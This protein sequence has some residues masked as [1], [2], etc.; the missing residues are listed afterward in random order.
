MSKKFKDFMARRETP[1]GNLEVIQSDYIAKNWSYIEYCIINK[2]PMYFMAL[3]QS[4]KTFLKLELALWALDKGLV[5]NV[6][7]NTTNLVG[8]NRQLFQR[9]NHWAWK[10]NRDVKTTTDK[11]ASMRPGRRS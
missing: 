11:S 4:G 2:L 3:T 8:A 1:L 5:D 6:I 10:N 7:I 9:A